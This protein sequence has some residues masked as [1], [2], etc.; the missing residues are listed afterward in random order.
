MSSEVGMASQIQYEQLRMD[1]GEAMDLVPV[2]VV[3]KGLDHEDSLVSGYTVA[4]RGLEARLGR[5]AHE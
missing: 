2:S 3:G 1:E 4:G 5:R